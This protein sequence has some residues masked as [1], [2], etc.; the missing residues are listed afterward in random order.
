MKNKSADQNKATKA[1]ALKYDGKNAPTVVA[2]GSGGLAEKIIAVA[3]EHNI[4]IHND[5]ILLEVLSRLEL[6]DEIPKQLYLAV[7]KIIAFAYFLQGKHPQNQEH[8]Q[9]T[10]Q[11]NSNLLSE[12]DN[13]DEQPN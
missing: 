3:K 2:K 1:T 8:Q 9:Y 4:H 12:F 7:A 6:G 10:S 11:T 13:D 5:P